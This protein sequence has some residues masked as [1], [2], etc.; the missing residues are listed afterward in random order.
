MTH[1][2]LHL[3]EDRWETFDGWYAVEASG[4]D[5]LDLPFDRLLSVVYYWATQEADEQ[6]VQKF[7]TRLHRPPPGVV[8]TTGPWTAEAETAAF[9][10]V[11]AMVQPETAKNG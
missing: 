5:P 1:R 2:L 4:N 9:K 6:E 8:P 7:D 11:K 10:S 3:M